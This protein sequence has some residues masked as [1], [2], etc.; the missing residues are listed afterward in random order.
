MA[1]SEL[2]NDSR[3]RFAK[4]GYWIVSI[5][6]LLLFFAV[7]LCGLIVSCKKTYSIV[8]INDL[9]REIVSTG[10]THAIISILDYQSEADIDAGNSLHYYA[11]LYACYQMHPDY[12]QEIAN[13][14]KYQGIIERIDE[15]GGQYFESYY[16][17][18]SVNTFIRKL[19]ENR[20]IVD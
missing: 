11:N 10:N 4:K 20:L 12:F 7:L 17:D 5:F 18:I 13:D 16:P 19:Q 8:Y 14:M 6:I 15:L 9:T 3:K 2:N 1:N